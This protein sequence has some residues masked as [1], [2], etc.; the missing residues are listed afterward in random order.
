MTALSKCPECK[1]RGYVH[2]PVGIKV[3]Q[4]QRERLLT[5][6]LSKAVKPLSSF[7]PSYE[8]PPECSILASNADTYGHIFYMLAKF[9]PRRFL[10]LTWDSLIT[11]W[12][13]RSAEFDSFKSISAA[14]E[15]L[16]IEFGT[17]QFAMNHSDEIIA[18]FIASL[19]HSGHVVI[20]LVSS[21]GSLKPYP[22]ISSLLKKQS[23]KDPKGC[24]L[25][26]DKQNVK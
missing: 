15:L 7:L 12:M 16:I 20:I 2:T 23:F 3:C 1:G 26:L 24:L 17:Q 11:C 8:L 21:S 9:F 25:F 19:I 5:E 6:Y 4:C 14:C 10:W 22:K 13:G 18:D